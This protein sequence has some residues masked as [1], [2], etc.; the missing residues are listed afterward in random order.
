MATTAC[1]PSCGRPPSGT[2]GSCRYGLRPSGDPGK[3]LLSGLDGR[4]GG[5]TRDARFD[6]PVD[7][8]TV[9][10]ERL[11][12]D[13]DGVSLEIKKGEFVALV[14]PSGAGKSTLADLVLRLYDPVAGRVTIDGRDVR[15]FRQ[16][17][18]RR[19]FGVVSQEALLFKVG[20]PWA[21]GFDGNVDN[22][23]LRQNGAL[24]TYNFENVP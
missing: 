21:P 11:G 9:V 1:G 3:A 17:A 6:V 24:V 5:A 13:L 22:F 12:L 7:Q 18:Y 16:A 14:G 20:G 19:L 8:V 4:P 23:R 15:A 2:Y 10:L